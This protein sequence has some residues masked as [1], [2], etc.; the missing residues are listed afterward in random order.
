MTYAREILNSSPSLLPGVD[1]GLL[2]EAA[3]AAF[4]CAQACTACANACLGEPQVQELVRCIRLNLHCADL[5][6]TTGR[7]I[8]RQ[9]NP[10]LARAILQA[11]VLACRLCAEECERHPGMDHCRVCAQACR[12][13]QQAC[14][15]V[16]SALPT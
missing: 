11:C 1:V 14:E 2:A 7:L 5:C 9:E 3:Q 15:R 6:D 12:G 16:L 8:S 13:C 4:D 10:E